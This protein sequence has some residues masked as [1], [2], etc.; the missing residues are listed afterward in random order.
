MY[1]SGRPVSRAR[2]DEGRGGSTWASLA[3]VDT[4]SGELIL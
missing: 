1:E 3:V 4:Q 2:L